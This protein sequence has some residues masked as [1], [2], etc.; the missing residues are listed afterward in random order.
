MQQEQKRRF[1]RAEPG[2]RPPHSPPEPLSPEGSKAM[3]TAA[4]L[5]ALAAIAAAA[6]ASAA[7]APKPVRVRANDRRR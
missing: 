5:I 2:H 6:A 4:V 7:P 3:L 1:G